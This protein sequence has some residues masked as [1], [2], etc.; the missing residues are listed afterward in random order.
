MLGAIIGDIVG[1]SYEFNPT[2]NYNFELFPIGA[3]FTDDTVC[4][5]AI[6]DALLRNRDFGQSLHEWC[7]R[8][9][10]P[11]GGYGGR[12]AR[13]V[14]SDTPRPYGSFGN[15]SAMRVSPIGWW[16]KDVVE[17]FNLATKSADCTHNHPLGING[18]IAVASAI[19]DSLEWRR[20]ALP[21]DMKVINRENIYF[22]AIR[23]ALMVLGYDTIVNNFNINLDDH[24]NKFDETCQGTVPVALHIIMISNSFEDALRRAV[25]LGGDADTL[26]AI[27]GSIAEAI[28][29]IPEWL[30]H[31]ALS[32]LPYEMRQVI[33][34]FRIQLHK[35][36]SKAPHYPSSPFGYATF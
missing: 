25:S 15:G 21:Y 24:R 34:Q 7:R 5:I 4:T 11:K 35:G 16:T 2:N 31:K 23:H 8:Y 18:A 22:H 10:N 19:Q 20:S 13:W 26:A 27:V 12:F 9:P 3:S 14:H 1:S 28:W 30:K 36:G 6:A 32:Y 17:L 29:G 33:H